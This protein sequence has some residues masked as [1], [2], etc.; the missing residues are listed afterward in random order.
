MVGRDLWNYLPKVNR[1][2]KLPSS[3]MG[4]S[5]MG[6]HF[7]NDDL[8][9]ESR[10]TD[11][12]DFAVTF[13]GTRDGEAVV[14]IRCEPKAGAA[15]V[16]GRILV[17]IGAE[18]GLPHRALYYGEDLTLARTLVYSDVR[19]FGGRRLPAILTITPADK[20]GESTTVTY[21]DLAFDVDAP[22]SLF[23]LRSLTN[24]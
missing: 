18:D 21:E 4:A 3:M 5:W 24:R 19:D 16:W 9:K 17:T 10:L 6:S 13:T 15:V 12:Y 8:V 20:P 1:V 23:S 2:V 11:D 14:E 7:T 22:D